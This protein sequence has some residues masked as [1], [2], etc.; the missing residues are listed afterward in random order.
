MEFVCAKS[1][2]ISSI[3]FEGQSQDERL[4][5]LVCFCVLFFYFP[6]FLVVWQT[7]DSSL[8]S[9]ADSHYDRSL[10]WKVSITTFLG[11]NQRGRVETVGLD[12]VR[13]SFCNVSAYSSW[14]SWENALLQFYMLASMF[15]TQYLGF[16]G[17]VREQNAVDWSWYRLFLSV[18]R[19]SGGFAQQRG[20]VC[21]GREVVA[22]HHETT[23]ALEG[24]F[25]SSGWCGSYLWY[26]KFAYQL[27]HL[28][29]TNLSYRNKSSNPVSTVS[30]CT[31][32]ISTMK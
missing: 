9:W 5:L 11:R 32:M 13:L 8:A 26:P 1:S 15:W 3:L 30:L 2:I 18:I 17:P 10:S 7:S 4:P 27:A 22:K 19:W 25:D 23:G 24:H 20:R 21:A 6:D 29:R 12:D 28:I 31:P 14:D 16:A